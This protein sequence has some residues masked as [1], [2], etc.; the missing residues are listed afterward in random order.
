MQV[1]GLEVAYHDPRGVSGMALA[2]CHQPARRVPQPVRLFLCG[3]G[4]GGGIHWPAS[5][6]TVRQA[7]RKRQRCHSPE[8]AD[9]L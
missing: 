1:N 6:M 9:G 7:R 5:F 2:L 4:T 8:L 3:M